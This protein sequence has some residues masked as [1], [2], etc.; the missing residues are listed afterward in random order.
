MIVMSNSFI[1][2]IIW[3]LLNRLALYVLFLAV[4]VTHAVAEE[5]YPSLPFKRL[6]TTVE[7]RDVLNKNRFNFLGDTTIN[8]DE[9][10]KNSLAEVVEKEREEDANRKIIFS[11]L[12]V[13]PDGKNVVWIDGRSQYSGDPKPEDVKAV[14]LRRDPLKVSIRANRRIK[15][16]KPGQVWTMSDNSVQE[17]FEVRKVSTVNIIEE[18]KGLLNKNNSEDAENSSAVKDQNDDVDLL[19]VLEKIN[20]KD[21]DDETV[22]SLNKAVDTL[23]MLDKLNRA[24]SLGEK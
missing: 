7:E 8:I 22:N 13:R 11:G 9:N 5:T 19:K 24:S 1:T 21:S 16:L 6:F 18:T 23:K 14:P 15:T 17:S 3:G 2:S 10:N 12:V 20:L 4:V